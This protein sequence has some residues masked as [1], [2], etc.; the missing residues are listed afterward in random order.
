MIRNTGFAAVHEKNYGRWNEI[1]WLLLAMDRHFQ[2]PR[3]ML[4]EYY[5]ANRMSIRRIARIL[6]IS[7]FSVQQKMVEY[8]LPRRDKVPTDSRS[9]TPCPKCDHRFS[10]VLEGRLL[11]DG[12][13][14]RRRLCKRC[15]TIMKTEEKAVKYS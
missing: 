15:N 13:Y 11:K 10:V 1:N 2:S 9:N 14:R 4:I 8:C 3:R 5:Y 7:P 12:I 6:N